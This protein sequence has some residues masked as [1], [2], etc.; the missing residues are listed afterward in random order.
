MNKIA[1]LAFI[2]YREHATAEDVE[3]VL[4]ELGY[5]YAI[6][7]LHDKDVYEAGQAK[8]TFKKPHYHVMV[9]GNLKQKQ[10]ESINIMLGNKKNQP[11]IAVRN[12]KD[13]YEYFFHKNAQEKAQ[14]EEDDIITSEQ[15]QVSFKGSGT[16]TT[17]LK[18]VIGLIES[19]HLDDYY[20]MARFFPEYPDNDVTEW[21][22]RNDAKLRTYIFFKTQGQSTREFMEG[23]NF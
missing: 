8:G 11:F 16:Q 14:Y 9:Q 5:E 19:E 20:K 15:F 2:V 1:C 4:T 12:T 10:K 3:N 13:M 21:V 17:T 7:P 23:Q 18:L 6:S 22:F